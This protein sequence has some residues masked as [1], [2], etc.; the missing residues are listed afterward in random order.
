VLPG[1]DAACTAS[2]QC[3]S[4]VCDNDRCIQLCGTTADCSGDRTCR[5]D[6]TLP[7]VKACH[8]GAG[9][10]PEGGACVTSADCRSGLCTG[11]NGSGT[12]TT[13]CSKDAH[14]GLGKACRPLRRSSSNSVTEVCASTSAGADVYPDACGTSCASQYC[15][16]DQVDCFSGCCRTADCPDYGGTKSACM[17]L[18]A[19]SVTGSGSTSELV[20]ACQPVQGTATDPLGAACAL[21]DG[22]NCRSNLCVNTRADGS[23]LP[24][25]S[26]YCSDACCTNED[27][28]TGFACTP[29]GVNGDMIS[30]CL[31]L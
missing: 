19:V 25:G 16:A 29:V 20:K 12:C 18:S 21:S 24:A 30:V 26:G 1:L 4:K 5:D 11:M 15:D 14:C 7:G 10:V 23:T 3:A 9:P 31:K 2:A 27:C 28:G 17:F 13:A 22:H 6:V 8:A